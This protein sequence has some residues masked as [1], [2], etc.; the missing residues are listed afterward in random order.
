MSTTEI[1]VDFRLL[2]FFLSSTIFYIPENSQLIACYFESYG[3]G[4]IINFDTSIFFF[5][6][7]IQNIVNFR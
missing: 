6:P 3:Y 2:F 7:V 5:P 4:K 1:V